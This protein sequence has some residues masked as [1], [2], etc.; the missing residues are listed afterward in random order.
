MPRDMV[1]VQTDLTAIQAA[2]VAQGITLAAH[3][4]TLAAIQSSLTVVDVPYVA[5]D[6]TSDAGSWT[7]E[8]A[9]VLQYSYMLV[10]KY[11]HMVC[12][13]Q[14]TTVAGAPTKLFAKLP[15]GKSCAR[16]SESYCLVYDSAG[17][18]PGRALL[19]PADASIQFQRV[20]GAAF[21]AGV[22]NVGVMGLIT[23]RIV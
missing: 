5:G 13:F 3:T 7:V 16:F 22:N 17:A 10:G 2:L 6:F 14:N 8:A 15:L 19:N 20:S 11:L 21:N 1:T 23:V 18:T 4:V 12:V 9:D